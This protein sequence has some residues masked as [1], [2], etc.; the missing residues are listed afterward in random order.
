MF[1]TATM[2]CIQ[3]IVLG[4]EAIGISACLP[5]G[6]SPIQCVPPKSLAI[7]ESASDSPLSIYIQVTFRLPRRIDHIIQLEL[8]INEQLGS[9]ILCQLL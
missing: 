1:D 6:L 4:P 7:V 8:V 2:K 9:S 3:G 5:A